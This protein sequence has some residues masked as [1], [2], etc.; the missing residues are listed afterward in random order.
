[1]KSIKESLN[2]FPITP[3]KQNQQ[4]NSEIAVSDLSFQASSSCQV[5]ENNEYSPEIETTK[6]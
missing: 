3:L 5:N 6:D 1:M 2:S 4:S